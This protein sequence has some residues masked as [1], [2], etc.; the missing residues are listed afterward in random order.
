MRSHSTLSS[1]EIRK[2]TAIER[3]KYSHRE[4]LI[5]KTN[6]QGQ[7]GES[8]KNDKISERGFFKSFANGSHRLSKIVWPLFQI[9]GVSRKIRKAQ[10]FYLYS[11]TKLQQSSA[12]MS[13]RFVKFCNTVLL[14]LLCY[15]A[16]YYNSELLLILFSN[17]KKKKKKCRQ[18]IYEFF[19]KLLSCI[20]I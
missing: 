17:N 16:L 14:K 2:Y 20:I 8:T 10:N 4:A 7:I 6:L 1:L 3:P 15:C 11:S 13:I 5:G 12:A 9:L 19:L 18:F